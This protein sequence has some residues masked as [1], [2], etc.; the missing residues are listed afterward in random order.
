MIDEPVFSPDE[1]FTSIEMELNNNFII[2]EGPFDI[3]IY[4]HLY[5]YYCK[6]NN[7]DCN[8]IIVQGG[9]KKSII[10][11]IPNTDASNY[12][13]LLDMD[14]DNHIYSKKYE[15]VFEL[16]KYSIENYFFDEN[17]VSHMLSFIFL[18]KSSIVR[19][20]LDFKE[21]YQ[22]WK[23]LITPLLPVLI[24][25]QKCYSGDKK[26]WNNKFL[27]KKNSYHLCEDMIDKFKNELLHE[28]GVVE[29]VCEQYFKNFNSLNN[30]TSVNFPGKLLFD[31]FYRYLKGICNEKKAKSFSNITN[32]TALKLQLVP[33]LSSNED[34]ISIIEKVSSYN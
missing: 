5:E 7:L 8:K 31:S 22:E 10:D 28:M 14:F 9:G 27:C 23:K 12:V 29:G 32:T 21:L 30:C 16:E 34:L 33:H 15:N 20:F 26:K 6:L 2:V 4:D 13:A 18:S 1:T 24:Y 11:W 25:Y 3:S 19:E 17:V